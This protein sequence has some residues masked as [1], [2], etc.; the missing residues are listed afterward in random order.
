MCGPTGVGKTYVASALGNAA[1]RQW[2]SVRYYRIS[3]LVGDLTLAKAD[4]SYPRLVRGSE[5]P[6]TECS[7]SVE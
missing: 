7:S 3:R 2:F 5:Q 6:W 1:C 4:G